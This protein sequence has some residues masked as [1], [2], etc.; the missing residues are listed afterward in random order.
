MPQLDFVSF[1]YVFNTLSFSYL[2][3]YVL[4]MLF[5]LKPIFREFFLLQTYPAYL[6]LEVML[7]TSLH[8]DKVVFGALSQ[9]T[10]SLRIIKSQVKKRWA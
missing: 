5:L 1:H 4:A 10:P 9:R 2:L 3:L 7:L 8:S 6:F